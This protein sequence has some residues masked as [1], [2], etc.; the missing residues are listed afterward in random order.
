MDSSFINPD[1]RDSLP[2]YLRTR[3]WVAE[4]SREQ[5]KEMLKPSPRS[6]HE[7]KAKYI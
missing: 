7:P 4:E 2:F 6:Y 1:N 5:W 3:V